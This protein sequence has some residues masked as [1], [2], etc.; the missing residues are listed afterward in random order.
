MTGV[1]FHVFKMSLGSEF[2][3]IVRCMATEQWKV[4]VASLMVLLSASVIIC[5]S[6]LPRNQFCKWVFLQKGSCGYF[7]AEWLRMATCLIHWF[8]YYSLWKFEVG[9]NFKC[10]RESLRHQFSFHAYHSCKHVLQTTH[11]LPLRREV[12]VPCFKGEQGQSLSK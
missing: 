10:C 4:L 9:N 7:R 12:L 11:L 3:V 2:K 8:H 5:L 6:Q 1:R